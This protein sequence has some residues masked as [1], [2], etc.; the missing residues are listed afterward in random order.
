MS[1]GAN[2]DVSLWRRP[3]KG[4]AANDT[5]GHWPAPCQG[6]V[7]ERKIRHTHRYKTDNQTQQ[8]AMFDP[9]SLT[10][11]RNKET[12]DDR[13]C[14]RIDF[15]PVN[16]ST[17][18]HLN[19]FNQSQLQQDMDVS[20]E[21]RTFSES[22]HCRLR[23]AFVPNVDSPSW[24]LK[25]SQTCKNGIKMFMLKRKTSSMICK[26]FKLTTLILRNCSFPGVKNKIVFKTVSVNAPSYCCIQE[27]LSSLC[28]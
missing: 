27:P 6:N 13:S 17:N 7:S 24:A 2:T 28:C 16:G 3:S 10:L 23:N 9:P 15:F 5:D 21:P 26:M 18:T 8:C 14:W 12:I 25:I 20:P 19:T 1:A 4:L 22:F 11:L